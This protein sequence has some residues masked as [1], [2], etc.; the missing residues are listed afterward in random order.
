MEQPNYYAVIP[1][2][3]RYDKEITDK[4][5]LLYGEIAALCNKNGV[6]TASN[7]YFASLYDV[8]T[9]TISTLINTLVKR[10]YLESEIIYKEGTKEI[11]NRYLKISKDPLLKN[12]KENNT[13]INNNIPPI[14]PLRGNAMKEKQSFSL[15]KQI[16]NLDL[17]E[18]LKQALID[19]AEMRQKIKKPLTAKALDL[20]I[21]KLNVLASNDEE[22]IAILEQSTM[23]CWQGI[24]PLRQDCVLQR[25]KSREQE[26]ID[27]F[28]AKTAKEWGMEW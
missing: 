11:Q 3:V 9:T 13:S 7:A 19:F 16:E 4:A 1:A 24:F 18:N 25:K 23:N 8:N 17:A 10:G 27:A 21:K 14:I 26:E 5:K 22:K 15:H 2:N 28:M 6:C 20:V 12:Q